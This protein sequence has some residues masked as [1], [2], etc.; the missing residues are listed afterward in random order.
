MTPRKIEG[1]CIHIEGAR[2]HNLKNVNVD[3]PRDKLVVVCG[4]SGSGKSTLAFDIV[5]AEGL[6]WTRL[7]DSLRPFPWN[8]R[9]PRTTPVPPWAR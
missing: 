6:W 2:Q 5:Y 9:P 1:P 7:K 3:I 8:S 4:P